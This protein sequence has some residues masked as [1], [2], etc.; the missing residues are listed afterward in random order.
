MS[1]IE[2][3]QTTAEKVLWR[4]RWDNEY[5]QLDLAFAKLLQ[6]LGLGIDFVRVP[7]KPAVEIKV[8]NDTIYQTLN[9]IT[10]TP[11]YATLSC[12]FSGEDSQKLY[13]ATPKW[14]KNIKAQVEAFYWRRHSEKLERELNLQN[15]TIS[16]HKRKKLEIE[17][18]G[19]AAMIDKILKPQALSELSVSDIQTILI[20]MFEK[21]MKHQFEKK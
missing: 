6:H 13:E 8:E 2:Q 17:K 14:D 10:Q 3:P 21:E 15:D 19:S 5:D 9:T 7:G 1:I 16:T 18:M 11:E 20:G 4:T 12:A